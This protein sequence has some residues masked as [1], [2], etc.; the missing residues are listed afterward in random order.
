MTQNDLSIADNDADNLLKPNTLSRQSLLMLLTKTH[1]VVTTNNDGSVSWE[2]FTFTGSFGNIS[3]SA[4]LC[5]NSD[6]DQELAFTQIVSAFVLK[7]HQKAKS[8]MGL[9]NTDYKQVL[10]IQM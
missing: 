3:Q 4:D 9:G 5:F 10:I 7:L 2:K 1:N 6:K 8:C